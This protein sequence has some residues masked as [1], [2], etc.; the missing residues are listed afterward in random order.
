MCSFA[1]MKLQPGIAGHS[2]CLLLSQSSLSLLQGSSKTAQSQCHRRQPSISG[3]W[4]FSPTE[5]TLVDSLPTIIED[6]GCTTLAG[7]AKSSARTATG[8]DKGRDGGTPRRLLRSDA[9]SCQLSYIHTRGICI[10]NAPIDTQI[11]TSEHLRV[12]SDSQKP[13]AIATAAMR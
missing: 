13:L 1:Q 6:L 9:P 7:L 11:L 8:L 2:L 3:N 12:C 10:C 4:I 5:V